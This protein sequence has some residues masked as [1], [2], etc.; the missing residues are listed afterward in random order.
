MFVTRLEW[1]FKPWDAVLLHITLKL[2]GTLGMT[3]KRIRRWVRYKGYMDVKEPA[4][5]ATIRVFDSDA[6]GKIR[7]VGTVTNYTVDIPG[8]YDR[9]WYRTSAVLIHVA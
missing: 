6:G 4:D 3:T 8:N 1:D 9:K 2:G 7:F 5:Y